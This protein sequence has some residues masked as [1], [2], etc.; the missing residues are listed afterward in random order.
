MSKNLKN[1]VISLTVTIFCSAVFLFVL[2]L[3]KE[4][5][6]TYIL[7]V[8]FA[9]IIVGLIVYINL[10]IFTKQIARLSSYLD[11]NTDKLEKEKARLSYI[12]NNMSQGIVV[13]DSNKNIIIINDK[14]ACLFDKKYQDY[15]GKQCDVIFDKE[16]IINYIDK[17][18][19]GESVK[20]Y[21]LSIGKKTF[22]LGFNDLKSNVKG[23]ASQD[24]KLAIIYTD[25]TDLADASALKQKFISNASHELKSPL[26]TIIGYQQLISCGLVTDIKEIEDYC[27]LTIKEAKRMNEIVKEMLELSRIEGNLDSVISDVYLA[28]IITDLIDNDSLKIKNKNIKV[29]MKLDEKAFAVMNESH[30][31][32]LL[33]NLI[34]NAIKYNVQGGSISITLTES[35]FI[36]KDTGI[37]ISESDQKKIFERFFRS[38]SVLSEEGSGLGLAIVKH[39]CSQY[40]FGLFVESKLKKGTTFTVKFK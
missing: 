1:I 11:E 37:G 35:E 8:I 2:Y 33:N 28:K 12:L 17:A 30:A 23:K 21:E 6:L 26:T 38:Y 39:I 10:L 36:I 18:L 9:S 19:R 3:V 40:N 27:S 20:D 25:I 16:I 14:V 34:E 31:Y 13:L 22:R 7:I 29:K 24:L 5:K 32:S 4:L 15:L